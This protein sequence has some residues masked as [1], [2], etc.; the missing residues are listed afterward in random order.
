MQPRLL[1][2]HSATAPL[3]DQS[4]SGYREAPDLPF[5]TDEEEEAAITQAVLEDD[6]GESIPLKQ[7]NANLDGFIDGLVA[8]ARNK[9]RK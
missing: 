8:E 9:L 1:R 2:R 5:M 7:S 4:G 3:A 6:R